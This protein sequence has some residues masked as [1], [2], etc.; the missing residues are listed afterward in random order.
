MPW[1]KGQTKPIANAA[2]TGPRK[3]QNQR[4]IGFLKI[5]FFN[6]SSPLLIQKYRIIRVFGKE[7]GASECRPPRIIRYD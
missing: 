1:K 4:R 3:S 5:P 2:T 7:N 6:G